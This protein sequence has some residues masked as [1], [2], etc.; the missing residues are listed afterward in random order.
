MNANER[1]LILKVEVY[2]VVGA[3]LEVLNVRGHGLHEKIYENCLC[4]EFRL[5]DVPYAQQERHR[6]FYKE[7]VV[8][9]YVPDIVVQEAIIVDTKTIERI[10]DHDRGQ[11]LTY[12]RITG[13]EVGV[14]LNFKHAR[15]EWERIVLTKE[16]RMNANERELEEADFHAPA[17]RR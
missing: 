17:Q 5:R 2:A 3:A 4:I 6:V 14:I 10:T 12:L 9:E 1:E 7:E 11:M 16:P 8:G 13:L 15:L